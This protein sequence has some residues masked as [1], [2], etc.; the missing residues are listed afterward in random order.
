[1][2]IRILDDTS[3]FLERIPED[4]T[5]KI[6]AHLK[7]LQENRTEGLLIKPLKGKIREMVVKQYRIVF[8]FVGSTGYV[9]DA[10]RKKSQK[11]PKRIIERAEKIY[12]DITR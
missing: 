1:M 9:V 6:I 3:D 5:A 12:K 10:F 2:N 4:D 8:F 7:S 11:T